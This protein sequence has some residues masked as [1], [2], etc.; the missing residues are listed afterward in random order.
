M[1]SLLWK[2]QF[3]F[4]VVT[5]LTITT[6]CEKHTCTNITWDTAPLLTKKKIKGRLK[7][8]DI[9]LAR[10]VEIWQNV[11]WSNEKKTGTFWT[12]GSAAFLVQKGKSYEQK[13]T[14]SMIRWNSFVI[15][16]CRDWNWWSLDCSAGQLSQSI[17]LFPSKLSFKLLEELPV[18]GCSILKDWNK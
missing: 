16:G 7:Y 11:L 14:I 4:K 13:S 10:P 6:N 18:W 1:N 17:H 15:R 2:F 12:N 8:E 9:N 3:Y 5:R